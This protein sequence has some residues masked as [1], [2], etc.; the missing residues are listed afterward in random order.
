MDFFSNFLLLTLNA[1]LCQLSIDPWVQEHGRGRE[2]ADFMFLWNSFLQES[3]R[4]I[5][6]AGITPN[7]VYWTNGLTKPEYISY[8]D[9]NLF[10]IQIWSNGQVCKYVQS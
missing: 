4:R 6:G 3:V 7:L 2:E 9:P 5:Q 1:S 8:L 10:S